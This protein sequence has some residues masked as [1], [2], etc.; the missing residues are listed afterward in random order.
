[1]FLKKPVV[2]VSHEEVHRYLAV[3]TKT[4]EE[5]SSAS[6]SQVVAV[7]AEVKSVSINKILSI[8]NI[9]KS[10]ICSR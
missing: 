10:S 9:E 1:M 5:I 2:K 3:Q 4:T 6:E 8:N 7:S